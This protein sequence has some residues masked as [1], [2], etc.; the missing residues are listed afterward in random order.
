MRACPESQ[1]R[2]RVPVL[3]RTYTASLRTKERPIEPGE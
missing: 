2:V 1:E 3:L